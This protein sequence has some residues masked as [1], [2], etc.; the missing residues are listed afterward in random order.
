VVRDRQPT[1]AS[2]VE[3]VHEE[4]GLVYSNE[5]V[6]T[7]AQSLSVRPSGRPRSANSFAR[8]MD[9]HVPPG[10]AKFDWRADLGDVYAWPQEDAPMSLTEQLTTVALPLTAWLPEIETPAAPP[11]PEVAAESTVTLFTAAT[12]RKLPR[13]WMIAAGATVLALGAVFLSSWQSDSNAAPES[14]PAA[15]SAPKLEDP[16]AAAPLPAASVAMS[17]QEAA[18][19]AGPAPAAVVEAPAVQI[20]AP[21]P[22]PIPEVLVKPKVKSAPAPA[23]VPKMHRA[24]QSRPLPEKS[25]VLGGAAAASAAA[26]AQ[27][28][29]AEDAARKAAA[30]AAAAAA[31]TPQTLCAERSFFTRSMCIY[32][33]CQKPEFAKLPMCVEN[34]KRTRESRS[35]RTE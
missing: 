20:A 23:R 33:Q 18:S 6:S 12:P 26:T 27:S 8:L 28:E 3:R 2:V 14:V 1:F 29:A 5:F 19:A 4:F 7:I 35:R 9:L 32:E 17:A 21:T 31:E 22:E 10:M 13:L 24:E 25:T 34:A 16:G 30:A 11:V 15:A